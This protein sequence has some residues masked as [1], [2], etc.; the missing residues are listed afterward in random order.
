MATEFGPWFAVI[1]VGSI[2]FPIDFLKGFLIDFCTLH[3]P[4]IIIE[5]RESEHLQGRWGSGKIG[6][7]Y[8]SSWSKETTA[9]PETVSLRIYGVPGLELEWRYES[10][11]AMAEL[12]C[13]HGIENQLL[14]VRFANNVAR[15]GFMGYFKKIAGI[16]PIFIERE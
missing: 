11:M 2:R 6:Y 1:N 8:E 16:R 4:D 15:R 12:M 14:R 3:K 13:G 10:P 9:I 5:N 7:A